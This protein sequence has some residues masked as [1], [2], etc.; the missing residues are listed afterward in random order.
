M[1]ARD[2]LSKSHPFQDGDIPVAWYI[3]ALNVDQAWK[4]FGVTG[5]GVLNVIH[6]GNNVAMGEYG[7]IFTGSSLATFDATISSG[8]LL[9]QVTMGSAS[10]ATIKVMSTAV[11]V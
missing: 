10:S 7:T 1:S 9:L 11:T 6:D 3:K 5:M 8:N 4:K 2:E